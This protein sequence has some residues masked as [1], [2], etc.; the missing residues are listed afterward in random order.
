MEK[1]KIVKVD[2]TTLEVVK[3]SKPL[4]VYHC[5]SLTYNTKKNLLVAACCRVKGNRMVFVDPV[6]LKVTGKKDIKL[7]KSI[8][9]L[10]SSEIHNYRGFTAIAYNEAHDR[11]A[12]RLRGSGNVIIFNGS[13]KPIRY[14]RLSGK[15]NYLLNQGM[16]SVGNYIYD[17]RSFKGRHRYS[18]VTVHTMSGKLVG[19]MRFAFGKS[20]GKELECIFHDGG[21][22]YAG[23]YCTTSQKNDTKKNHVKRR[24]KIIPKHHH[25]GHEDAPD[26]KAEYRAF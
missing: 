3:V 17:V 5:N 4:E 21:Q 8:K 24:N 20:P 26:D 15:R 18:M 16:D 14:V 19:E 25:S 13:M 1:C 23:F 6:K 11:Y 22:F 10:P 7:S 2:L 9:G 12:G